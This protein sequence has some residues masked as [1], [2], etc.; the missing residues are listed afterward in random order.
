MPMVAE[1]AAE[2][3]DALAPHYDA[4]TEHPNYPNWV[5]SL[6]ALARHHGL[7]GRRALDVGC[8]TGSSS[9]PLVELGYDVTGCDASAGMLALAS[10]RLPGHV[11]LVQADLRALPELGRFDLVWCVNDT[12]NYLADDELEPAF[13]HVRQAL[14]VDGRFLF[15]VNTLHGYTTR[16]A[17]THAR[18]TESLAMF[19]VGS[20][21][22][23]PRLGDTLEARIEVFELDPSTDLWR[24]S[25]SH[26]RQ[27]CHAF[28]EIREALTAAGLHV[29][30]RYGLTADAALQPHVG[31]D[32]TK[33]IFV[34]APDHRKE[35]S[36]NGVRDPLEQGRSE[37]VRS[38]G[39]VTPAGPGAPPHRGAPG[40]APASRRAP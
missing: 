10:A 34:V 2:A 7:T 31:A 11:S 9:A 15:D 3:Y 13:A 8:G 39:L 22:P 17:P 16:F 38:Q 35:V 1:T 20:G 40:P 36:R 30:G 32:H 25:T 14:A 24:R 6:E 27:R 5:R 37:P 33:A 12:I 29:V 18:A 28:A 4:F 26:H 21:E 23:A 19:W